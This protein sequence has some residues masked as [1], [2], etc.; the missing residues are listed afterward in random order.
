MPNNKQPVVLIRSSQIMQTPS[1]VRVEA[2][3]K[4]LADASGVSAEVLKQVMFANGGASI[5]LYMQ[6]FNLE[7]EQDAINKIEQGLIYQYKVGKLS[8]ADFY[9]KLKAYMQANHGVDFNISQENFKQ[10]WNKM[11]KITPEDIAILQ[12]LNSHGVRLHV[13]CGSNPAHVDYIKAQLQEQNLENLVVEYTTSF[14]SD[15]AT[16]ESK[17]IKQAG[18]SKIKSGSF[19]DLSNSSHD[20]LLQYCKN[21]FNVNILCQFTYMMQN[22]SCYQPSTIAKQNQQ[23]MDNEYSIYSPIP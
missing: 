17:R 20:A 1:S 15:I 13:L 7:T 22:R 10:C 4:A 6:I 8:F 11:C 12:E 2:V 18:I 9:T 23:Q 3:I 19:V 21:A 16:L 5:K 14:D